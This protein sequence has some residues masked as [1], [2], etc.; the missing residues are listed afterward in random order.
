MGMIWIG[1]VAD[2]EI[3]KGGFKIFAGATPTSGHV[4]VTCTSCAL[5]ALHAEKLNVNKG[6]RKQRADASYQ[7]YKLYVR[8]VD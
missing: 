8:V 5:H 2:L 1:P 3:L 7:V 6:C 4:V